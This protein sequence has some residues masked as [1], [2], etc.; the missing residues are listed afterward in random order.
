MT[1]QL[2]RLE[3]LENPT[4]RQTTITTHG[5]P[6]H[7][8]H[9]VSMTPLLLHPCPFCISCSPRVSPQPP[10]RHRASQREANTRGE[11]LQAAT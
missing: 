2:E 8:P 9:V 1:G 10:P 6:R 7:A 5:Q 11:G 4:Y 3:Q